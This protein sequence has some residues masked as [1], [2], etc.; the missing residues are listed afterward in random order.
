M[1]LQL[2][3]Q[4]TF[5]LLF[6]RKVKVGKMEKVEM[7]KVAATKTMVEVVVVEARKVN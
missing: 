6:P 3:L 4:I 1:G 2:T 5:V 7:P